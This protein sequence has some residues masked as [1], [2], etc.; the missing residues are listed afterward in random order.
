MISG[1]SYIR[2]WSSFANVLLQRVF[3]SAQAV[4]KNIRTVAPT[5]KT[6]PPRSM[7]LYDDGTNKRLYF[8]FDGT[9]AYIDFDG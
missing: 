9:I 1:F 5:T 8:N 7:A 2:E 4:D 6:L 3:D